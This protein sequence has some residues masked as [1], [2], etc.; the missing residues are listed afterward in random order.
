MSKE[1]ATIT[2]SNKEN[3]T[4]S[5]YSNFN[6]EKDL[7]RRIRIGIDV[8]GTFTKAVAIDMQSGKIM[9]KATTLTTHSS[10]EGVSKG[11]IYS[12]HSII[13]AFLNES[14]KKYKCN[15]Y[16]TYL[17]GVLILVIIQEMEYHQTIDL[18]LNEQSQ[19][20]PVFEYKLHMISSTDPYTFTVISLSV[21]VTTDN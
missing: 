9:G 6:T 19:S 8:G 14:P 7:K 3:K 11:V 1:I 10:V 21:D 20:E 17:E 2:D 16:Y 5:I 4:Q 15:P 12:L 18:S 13:Q